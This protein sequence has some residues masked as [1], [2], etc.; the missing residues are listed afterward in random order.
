MLYNRQSKSANMLGS[1]LGGEITAAYK[2]A[3]NQGAFGVIL[4]DR[5]YSVT[6]QRIFDKLT[7]FEKIKVAI[8]MTWE[9]LTMSLYKLAD[10]IKKTESDD[11][12]IREEITR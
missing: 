10:Y 8:I 12:F 6:I 2:T 11:K 7:A 5:L 3:S 1:K 9:V 4:G